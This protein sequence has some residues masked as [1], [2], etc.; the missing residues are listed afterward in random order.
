MG[1]TTS[2]IT[3]RDNV[4]LSQLY[5]VAQYPL[6]TALINKGINAQGKVQITFVG[7]SITMGTG[8]SSPATLSY[9]SLVREI[10]NENQN[11]AYGLEDST[12]FDISANC[13]YLTSTTGTTGTAGPIG[14]SLVL[15]VGQTLI[16]GGNYQIIDFFYERSPGAG[17]AEIKR[18][19]V[20]VA[21]KSMAGATASNICTYTGATVSTANKNSTWTITATGG[22]IE[23]TG[24]IRRRVAIGN[25][26]WITRAAKS[27]QL[28]SD[29]I[30]APRLA[31]LVAM[32][33]Y[34]S[35]SSVYVLA[36][37]INDIY[38]AVGGVTSAQYI[39]NLRVLIAG[40][41]GAG[42][43]CVLTV[44][45]KANESL[46][47]PR[48][49]P[50]ENY[51]TAI[52]NLA[53]ELDLSVIDY[54]VYDFVALSAMVDS[55]HPNDL[56]HSLMSTTVLNALQI[57]IIKPQL[58]LLYDLTNNDVWTAV[59]ASDQPRVSV[60]GND[61]TLLGGSL[62]NGSASLVSANIPALCRPIGRACAF[63]AVGGGADGNF[64]VTIGT[65]GDITMGTAGRAA[66][67]YEGMT[68]KI[69]NDIF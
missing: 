29:Y 59:S 26:A 9:V 16:F 45:T 46:V 4:S 34:D 65:N 36:L 67:W 28:I 2:G 49:E 13:S 37:G 39:A 18:D 52:F 41:S 31:S 7:D 51:K 6:A 10:L 12:N 22:T 66:C 30:T 5:D 56:G 24:L 47:Q 35:Q 69:R 19:G 40:L 61:A 32:S 33:S 17:S 8:A 21:T 23:I 14:Q 27:G 54:S 38:S 55:L 60:V 48:Y 53:A 3:G 42:K 43:T 50:Y 25:Y 62:S 44:P 15:A 63:S 58:R 68:Y 64:K 57:P 11:G 20:V 1:I